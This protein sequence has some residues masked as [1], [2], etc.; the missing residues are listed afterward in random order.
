MIDC[1]KGIVHHD[2]LEILIEALNSNG[3][4][5]EKHMVENSI[6]I[7]PDKVKKQILDAKV[8]VE[9]G[10]ASNKFTLIKDLETA[11]TYLKLLNSALGIKTDDTNKEE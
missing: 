4:S 10:K 1:K 8:V 9:N 5:L 11:Q 2:A 6:F 7:C 3:M